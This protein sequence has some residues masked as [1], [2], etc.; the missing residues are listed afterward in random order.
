MAY[1]ITFQGLGMETQ[2]QHRSG[3]R[4][5]HARH[6]LLLRRAGEAL[7]GMEHVL[8]ASTSSFLLLRGEITGLALLSPVEQGG[9]TQSAL[10]GCGV[11]SNT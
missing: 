9:N 4:G 8:P 2:Y 6:L 3:S 5:D 7:I 1:R 11:G 10:S